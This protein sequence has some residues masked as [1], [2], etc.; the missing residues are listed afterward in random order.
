[1]YVDV[2]DDRCCLLDYSGGPINRFRRRRYYSIVGAEGGKI[3]C[4]QKVRK[5]GGPSRMRVERCRPISLLHGPSHGS[6]EA[7]ASG[8]R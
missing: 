1:M 8:S 7:E 2:I 5:G 4:A 3:I 6:E